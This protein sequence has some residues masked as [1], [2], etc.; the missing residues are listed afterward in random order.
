VRDVA[1]WLQNAVE[2][3]EHRGLPELRP[4]L[5]NLAQA[6]ALLRA[7]DWNDDAAGSPPE[8]ETD[9]RKGA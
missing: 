2:D 7:A 5:E 4:L 3:A 8:N 1:Q 9:V 6:T